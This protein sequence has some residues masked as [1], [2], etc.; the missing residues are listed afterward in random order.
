VS[1]YVSVCV[2]ACVRACDLSRARGGFAPAD[3]IGMASGVPRARADVESEVLAKLL[4]RQT[5]VYVRRCPAACGTYSH[6]GTPSRVHATRVR[7]TRTRAAGDKDKIEPAAH[8]RIGGT[9][10]RTRVGAPYD[11]PRGHTHP[12]VHTTRDRNRPDKETHSPS[13]P[14][15][16]KP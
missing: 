9:P 2:R 14:A 6:S 12:I 16:N 1:V 3:E 11:E 4:Q 13:L 7:A 5:T 15:A 8:P 10:E